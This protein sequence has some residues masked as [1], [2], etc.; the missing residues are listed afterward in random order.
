ML[1]TIWDDY[2]TII[3]AGYF[4][5]DLTTESKNKNKFRSLIRYFK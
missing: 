2:S 4:N 5:M 1:I 3:E